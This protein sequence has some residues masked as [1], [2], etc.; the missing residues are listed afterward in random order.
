M[1]F[2][3]RVGFPLF[4]G[5]VVAILIGNILLATSILPCREAYFISKNI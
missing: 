3:L 1:V 4:Y 5:F 2:L